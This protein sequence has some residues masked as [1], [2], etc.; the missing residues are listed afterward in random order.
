MRFRCDP[1]WFSATLQSK[2]ARRTAAGFGPPVLVFAGGAASFDGHHWHRGALDALRCEAASAPVVGSVG[3][4]GAPSSTDVRL[5]SWLQE[6]G[7]WLVPFVQVRAVAGAGL[8]LVNTGR[9]RI[10]KG[11]VLVCVPWSLLV[12]REFAERDERV[13][14]LCT[15]CQ[16]QCLS[17]G[18]R[19]WLVLQATNPPSDWAPWIS[20]LPSGPGAGSPALPLAFDEHGLRGLRGTALAADA[21][22][23]R[24]RLWTE[25]ELLDRHIGAPL[26]GEVDWSRWLW[27]Q[28]V[29]ST[30]SSTLE[31]RPGAE[32]PGLQCIIPVV[33]FA[34]HSGNPNAHVV[35]S[36]ATGAELIAC[37]DIE[38]GEEVLIS[39]GQ[40]DAS[41]FLFAFGFLP[42]AQDAAPLDAIVAPLPPALSNE[43]V[44]L[45][46]KLF[47][48]DCPPLLRAGPG[49]VRD[50][51]LAMRQPGES[52]ADFADSELLRLLRWLRAWEAELGPGSHSTAAAAL[53]FPWRR[54]PPL[55]FEELRAQHRALVTE[56]VAYAQAEMS[57]PMGL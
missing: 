27:A 19:I 20:S 41:Q 13:R 10:S 46:A 14:K 50:L 43:A 56:A 57:S 18:L 44:E 51:L 17:L 49:G 38:A 52:G 11:T 16:T 6:R 25:W 33:D 42:R 37:R 40:H 45:R 48:R 55:E 36:S 9:D 4:D 2:A 21:R 5:R 12:S 39:Y 15:L 1:A 26:Y 8:G 28:A 23:L 30:R 34:N 53:L 32:G 29:L 7:G 47:G 24:Q 22:G 54:A 3:S 31:L 35:A